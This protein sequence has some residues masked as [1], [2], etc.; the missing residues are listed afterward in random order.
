ML[1]CHLLTATPKPSG[2]P[3]FSTMGLW[4]MTLRRC[5]MT[6]EVTFLNATY[7]SFFDWG[8]HSC[9]CN[10]FPFPIFVACCWVMMIYLSLAYCLP[11]LGCWW[12][13]SLIATWL[14]AGDFCCC[15]SDICWPLDSADSPISSH[16][17]HSCLSDKFDP[18]SYY[19]DYDLFW[20]CAS[21]SLK[22]ENDEDVF[23][24]YL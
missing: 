12:L 1:I 20:S 4:I 16:L 23:K 24:P 6:L 15:R 5:I 9:L 8:F 13:V 22:A 10:Y 18:W 17:V 19:A 11:I 2:F 7:S 14:A 21:H 3:F